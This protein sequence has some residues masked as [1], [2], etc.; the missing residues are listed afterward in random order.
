MNMNEMRNLNADIHKGLSQVATILITLVLILSM[1]PLQGAGVEN[2]PV[3]RG[4]GVLE[5]AGDWVIEDGEEFTYDSN[6]IIVNGNLTILGSLELIDCEIVMNASYSTIMVNGEMINTRTNVSGNEIFYYFIVYGTFASTDSH[7]SDIAGSSSAPKIGG[8]QLYS[9]DVSLTGGSILN[10]EQAGLFVDVNLTITDLYM[11]WNQVNVVVYKSSP[12]FMDCIMRHPGDVSF[13]L[14]NG[15]HPIFIGE[16]SATYK[17]WDVESSWSTGHRLSVHVA[18]ENGTSIQGAL[19]NASSKE[20]DASK[21]GIT[22]EFGWVR[23]MILPE[24]TVY[25]S[26]QQDTVYSPYLV[27]ATMFGLQVLESVQLEEDKTVEIILTGDYFGQE[28]VRGDFNGDGL[29][30]LAVGVP[31]NASGTTKPGAVFIYFNRGDLDIL[32]IGESMADLTIPGIEGT[33]FGSVLAAGDINGDGYDELLLA[34]PR[35]SE[36]GN[37]AGRVYFFFGEEQPSWDNVDDAALFFEGDPGEMYGRQMLCGNINGD[38]YDDFVIGD[39]SNSFVFFGSEDPVS[40][41]TTVSEFTSSAT[42]KGDA[43][44]TPQLVTKTRYDDDDRYDLDPQEQMHLTNF[45]SSNIKGDP[46]EITLKFQFVTDRYY[47]YNQQ[48]R[49]YAYYSIDNENWRQTVRPAAPNNNWDEETTL[50]FDLLADGLTSLSDLEN[51]QLWYKN[52]EGTEG[53]D[54]Y[55]HI[56]FVQVYVRAI[57]FGANHTLPAGNLSIG[58]VNDD[59]YVDLLVSDPVQQA[60][61]FGGPAG[62]SAPELIEVSTHE[63]NATNVLVRGENMTISETR[64]YLNG[65]FDERWNGWIQTENTEGQQDGGV[66]WSIIDQENGDW[67][68]HEGATGGFGSDRDTLGGGGGGG[69]D[70]RGMLRTADFL[71]TDDME[72]INFWYNFKTSSFEQAGGQQGSVADEVRYALYS[73]DN[74][75]IL[76]ELAGWEPSG[77]ENSAEEDGFVE[78]NITS[79]LGETVYF[80]M[81]IITNRGNSDRAIVQVDNLTILPPSDVPYYDN[82]SFESSWFDFDLNLTSITPTWIQALNDG[83]ISVKFRFTE[84]DTW[85]SLTNIT[86]GSKLDPSVPSKRFQYR[87]EMTGDTLSSPFLGSL[88][89]GYLLEGKMKP[90]YLDTD[91]GIVKLGDIDGDG[92]AD[93]LFLT[94]DGARSG[95]IDL[96]YGGTTVHDDYN[97]SALQSFYSGNVNEFS[98]I[99]LEMDG[100]VEVTIAGDNIFILDGNGSVLYQRDVEALDIKG[101]TAADPEFELN[102][103]SLYFLPF[104]DNE[105]RILDVEVPD[106]V[107]PDAR[108]SIEVPVGN[109]GL[110]D[111]A[112]LMIYL[113]ITANG[114]LEEFTDTVD[115]VSLTQDT[116]IFNWD[117]PAEE[118]VTYTI[119]VEVVLADDRVPGN[120]L[121][122]L[123]VISMKHG[124]RITSSAPLA[125]AHGGEELTYPILIENIGTFETENVTLAATIPG[126]WTKTFLHEDIP[127]EWVM[128]TDSAELTFTVTSPDDEVNDDF[129]LNLSA[130]AASAVDYLDLT[131]TILR[132]D[133]IVREIAL[134]REDGTKTNDT[135]HGVIGEEGTIMIEIVNQGPTY[136]GPFSV[137][138]FSDL[139]ELETFDNS[140]LGSGESI[141]YSYTIVHDATPLDLSVEVDVHGEVPEME[142]GNNDL[143]MS[144]T[145]KDT[146]SV[147]D[148]EVIG[149]IVN[150]FGDGVDLAEVTLIWD[151]NEIQLF[152]DENGTFAHTIAM[153]DYTDTTR[154]YVN[155]TDGV[156]I[157]N[158]VVILYSEDGGVYLYLVLNQYIVEITGP[159]TVSSIETDGADSFMVEITNLGNIEA[160]FVITTSEL[161]DNWSA[162]FTGYPDGRFSLAV[163]GTISIEVVITASSDPLLSMGYHRYFTTILVYSER[164]PDANDTYGHGFQV[165]PLRSI[166]ISPLGDDSLDAVPFS[167]VTYTFTVEN[168]GNM[169][170]TYIPMVSGSDVESYLFDITYAELDIGESSQFSLKFPMPRIATGTSFDLEVG[171]SQDSVT[172]TF[173]T[174]SALDYYDVGGDVPTSYNARPGDTLSVTIDV[175]NTGNLDQ[176]V[177][178]ATWTSRS[179]IEPY[180]RE[181]VLAMD[182][183]TSFTIPLVIPVDALFGEVIVVSINLSSEG[184]RYVNE[185]FEINIVESFGMDLTLA[186]TVII[187][188]MDYTIY[189]YDIDA[190]NTGNGPNTFHFRAEGSHPHYLSVPAPITLQP[191]EN[192]TI[193]ARIIVPINRTSVIDNYLVPTDGVRDFG[194]LNL[195]IQSYSMDIETSISIVQDQQGMGTDDG[196]GGST[197]FYP[198]T[199]TNNGER[200]ERLTI[201]LV[202]PEV[203]GYDSGDAQW[204][205]NSD[206][207]VLELF[208]GQTGTFRMTVQTPEERKYWGSDLQLILTSDSERSETITLDKPPISIINGDFPDVITHEVTLTFTGSQSLWSILEYHWDFGDGTTEA[209]STVTKTFRTSGEFMVR[210]MIIDEI[211]LYANST[212]LITVNNI[213]PIASILTTPINRTVEEGKPL[214]LD[215]SNSQDRDGEIVA[216]SWDFGHFGDFYDGTLPVIEHS[217]DQQGTYYVSLRVTDNMGDSANTT[218][219]VTVVQKTDTTT[220]NIE[221][222]EKVTT[223]VLSYAPAALILIILIA[224]AALILHKRSVIKHIEEK[225]IAKERMG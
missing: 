109:L 105:L 138:L 159:D 7:Y 119:N 190:L 54:H 195:R 100:A 21:Q 57:P 18:Y 41:F 186:E 63:G 40:D 74:D 33:D 146:Q 198:V 26:S 191:G 204:E 77:D 199:V 84:N 225:I 147:G 152:T 175:M 66:R 172:S 156:N 79:L 82:G 1:I 10:C 219:T 92:A 111:I 124:V 6:T 128:I 187:P 174:T 137:T 32:D 71:I 8:L 133:L 177:S 120:N 110:N 179:G 47:G 112:S 29:Q 88:S 102:T 11:E 130:T 168:L 94:D 197:Y 208:P 23:D 158:E 27:S 178:A 42:T 91:H 96:H 216:Y 143:D 36:N 9:E 163:N 73:A 135:L 182:E 97:V 72:T 200:F 108:Q 59:G 93:L 75:S 62:I 13:Y 206:K 196:I 132:P 134:F 170:D 43:D 118:G 211:G 221:P 58:D 223:D 151:D 17:I 67:K 184:S 69:R 121:A 192:T 215:G 160:D 201:D 222:T 169:K 101:N 189:S 50:T 35:S 64:P 173:V 218:I 76:M 202:I 157:T 78:E 203:I 104:Y 213:A 3:D 188:G 86:S 106:L 68:V 30:D 126:G 24:Q 16:E 14:Y 185:T 166:V 217:Y 123:D 207:D 127:V 212:L 85:D 61:Y 153:A 52:E 162:D 4:D 107:I 15:S 70:C 210:L 214:V 60:V 98:F 140:G 149:K 31:K 164:Y 205:G 12:V 90:L 25:G 81:E 80:G 165:A 89:I 176:T 38:A 114:Y 53:N 37:D 48:E 116:Y 183:D 167:D 46:V 113:N 5:T 139:S 51:F 39:L 181:F 20:Y 115:L 193:T 83:T 141:W 87:V 129:T 49:G 122:Q 99:D 95:G 131:S 194:D 161:P 171:G 145:I 136:S 56:D 142:E 148:Y 144:F 224:G 180:F 117:V 2:P 103:G 65:Q 125:S 45:T 19:I 220:Q 154:L 22:D 34:T 44:N 28:L 155:V 150:I 209:G 55:I